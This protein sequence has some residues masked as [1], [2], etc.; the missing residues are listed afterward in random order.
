MLGDNIK[1]ARKNKKLS[2]R[3]LASKIGISTSYLQQLELGQ[4]TN[5][6]IEIKVKLASELNISVDELIDNTNY[7]DIDDFEEIKK[8]LI[9]KKGETPKE[10]MI[11]SDILDRIDEIKSTGGWTG[12][13]E[14]I[15]LSELSY[16]AK[17]IVSPADRLK[18]YISSKNYDINKLDEESLKEIDKKFSDILELEFYKLNK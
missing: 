3:E 15:I 13:D 11:I 10:S 17:N 14:M 16:L 2:Q 12:T 8:A 6:S 18:Y 5:P 7:I 4:K 1:K 9:N